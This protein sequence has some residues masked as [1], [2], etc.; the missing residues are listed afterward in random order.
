MNMLLY[1]EAVLLLVLYAR[2][3]SSGWARYCLA[4]FLIFVALFYLVDIG[5]LMQIDSSFL[6]GILFI[7][8][9]AI[10]TF[11]IFVKKESI[12]QKKEED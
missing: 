10:I 11:L 12:M 1:A 5:G 4:M 2:Y 7:Y 8:S 3:T 6:D 9:T